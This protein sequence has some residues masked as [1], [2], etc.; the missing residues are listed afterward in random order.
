MQKLWAE[1]SC[2]SN[3]SF[4]LLRHNNYND[5]LI[6]FTEAYP[7]RLLN[8]PTKRCRKELT[9]IKPEWNEVRNVPLELARN[10]NSPGRS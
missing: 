8:I 2:L 4:F 7:A 9:P 1:K 3:S 6:N 10:G 5:Y